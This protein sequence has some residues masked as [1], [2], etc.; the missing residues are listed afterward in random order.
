MKY[1]SEM[2][3]DNRIERIVK[4]KVKHYYTDW[5]NY[6]RPKYMKL[7]GTK[8]RKMILVVRTCG[9]YL[10]SIDELKEY[11]FAKT[12]YEY[13]IDYES[14]DYYYIDLDTRE[15]VKHKPNMN[16]LREVA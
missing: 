9:T 5:K 3:M 11:D 1:A 4:A 8:E 12:V 2:D 16:W 10:Y 15:V 13:Y 14:A 7:K 6:D